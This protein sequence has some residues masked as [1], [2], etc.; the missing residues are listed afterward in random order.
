MLRGLYIAGGGMAE[1]STNLDILTNNIANLQTDTF[2]RDRVAFTPFK[3]TL[4]RHISDNKDPAPIGTMP[5]GTEIKP[6]TFIDFSQGQLVN[7]GDDSD[8]ALDGQGFIKVML[9]DGTTRYTRNGRFVIAADGSLLDSN[10]RFILDDNNEKINIPE[11][12][13]ITVMPQGEIMQGNIQIAKIGLVEIDDLSLLVKNGDVTYSL[14]GDP[15][16]HE[17][18]AQFT[19]ILQGYVEKTNCSPIGLITEMISLMREYE[20]SQKAVQVIDQSLD[21]SLQKLGSVK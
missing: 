13:K 11:I 15:A 5:F 3:N 12:G 1:R 9:S 7:S 19:S 10:G 20:A 18:E 16:Q 21:D 8:L 6:R 4:L 2:K 14:T 17:S